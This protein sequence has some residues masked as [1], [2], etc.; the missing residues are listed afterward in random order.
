[1]RIMAELN[2]SRDELGKRIEQKSRDSPYLIIGMGTFVAVIAS[3]V[4][5][6]FGR[7]VWTAIERLWG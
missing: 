4:I 7:W 1:M 2:N 5:G 3:V 6:E